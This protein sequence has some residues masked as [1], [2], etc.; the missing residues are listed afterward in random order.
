MFGAEGSL[1]L[2][3]MYKLINNIPGM[4]FQCI[5]DPPNLKFTI[6]SKGCEQ[7]TGYTHFQFLGDNGVK[8]LD[9]VH[10]DDSEAIEYLIRTTLSVGLP[11]ESM[12]RIVTCDGTEKR[13]LVRCSVV[14]TNQEGLPYL[15]EG[16]FTDIT[17]PLQAQA[18]IMANR[19]K[20]DFLSR[21]SHEIRTPMNAVIGMAEIG[22]QKDMPDN[23]R[24]YTYDIKIAGSKLMSVLNNVWD[25]TQ[26]EN[27]ELEIV[28]E[29]YVLSALVSEVVDSTAVQLKASPVKFNVTI[30]SS[31]PNHLIGDV[32]RLRQVMMNIL[33][34]AVKF[35]DKNFISL[36][37]GGNTEGDIFHLRIEV[38]DSGRG[39]REEDINSIFNPYTQFDHKNI[40]G[41]GLGLAIAHNLVR[42]MGGNIEVSSMYKVGSV[43]TVTLPQIIRSHEKICEVV[44]IKDINVLIFD[45]GEVVS[46]TLNDLGV[47]CDVVSSVSEFYVS[48]TSDL[49]SH[50]FVEASLYDLFTKKCPDFSNDTKIVVIGE[51]DIQYYGLL[52]LPIY[53]IPVANI[54][55]GVSLS[56]NGMLSFTAPEARVLIVD[57]ISANLKVVEGLLSPYK[58][59][60]D[61]CECGAAAIEAVKSNRYDLIFMDYLMPVMSGLEATL[62]IRKLTDCATNCKNIPIVALTANA[63]GEAKAMFL[64]NGFDDFLV[65]PIDMVI[66]HNLV[67]K[68]IPEEKQQKVSKS[69]AKADVT[70]RIKIAGIDVDRGIAMTG[71]ILDNYLDILRTY[72]QD[73]RQ[74]LYELKDCMARGDMELYR[75]RVHALKGVSA[76]IGA[77]E[78]SKAAEALELAEER[79]DY[80]FIQKNNPGFLMK[81]ETLLDNIRPAIAEDL[82]TQA[83]NMDVLKSELVKLKTAMTDYNLANINDY[84]N[85]LQKYL[86]SADIGHIINEIMQHKMMGEYEEA[87]I[88]IDTI[89]K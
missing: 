55:N 15:I 2:R 49:F 31:I 57:D 86:L 54:L 52:S 34:N 6:V 70:T 43:F 40:E 51:S 22:L 62:S 4:A 28:A 50:A 60:L 13:V 67:K 3:S 32:A 80:A 56:A 24:E 26:I 63:T 10:L 69:S 21:M 82:D 41:T 14:E 20:S 25:F 78:L 30:D 66:L 81:L 33:T 38:S 87:V 7:L 61:F 48:L 71:G 85:N 77:L 89:L 9:L 75:V 39:I 18:A 23:V 19:A 65:K 53:C 47:H 11:F 46:H 44:N 64:Q 68:W 58:M 76:S 35:T 1:I 8:F 74:K 5:H 16:L 29:E 88:L 73:G 17:N 84:A 42:L 83:V 79:S 12:F 45:H 37:M 72:H 27:G 36:S 59:T